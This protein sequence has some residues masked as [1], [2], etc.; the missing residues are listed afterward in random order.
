MRA[1]N[2]VPAHPLGTGRQDLR[3]ELYEAGAGKA[4]SQGMPAL[5][6]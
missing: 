1:H 4:M 6:P 3:I 5:Q 2:D